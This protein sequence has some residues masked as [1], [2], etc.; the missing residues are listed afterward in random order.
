MKRAF[1][2]S[3][4]TLAVLVATA[5]YAD[6]NR[7]AMVQD[8][9]F[10]AGLIEQDGRKN[11]SAL[12]Q[13]GDTNSASVTQTGSDNIAAR[14]GL[15]A[16]PVERALTQVGDRNDLTVEQTGDGEI[17]FRSF[18]R[19]RT[20]AAAAQNTATVVQGG[21]DDNLVS[22]LRQVN[23]DASGAVNTM[24]VT[25]SGDGNIIGRRPATGTGP[26][27]DQLG[28]GNS[29]TVTQSGKSNGAA[30]RG[31]PRT[32]DFGAF[33]GPFGVEQGTALQD[34]NTNTLVYDAMGNLNLFGTEQVGRMNTATAVVTGNRNENLLLQNGSTNDAI[35]T[36]D[37]NANDVVTL[38]YIGDNTASTIIS[39][40]RN[41]AVT[42]QFSG[43]GSNTSSIVIDGDLAAGDGNDVKILQDG[44]NQS[45]VD[46]FG[47]RSEVYVDQD[48]TNTST[49]GITGATEGNGN[50]VD[51]NQQNA[52]VLPNTSAIAISGD[53]ND[54]V[55]DQ[56]EQNRLTVSVTGAAD[57]G[58][59]DEG[60]GNTLSIFQFGLNVGTLS[61]S[62]DRN[63]VILFQNGDRMTAN[64]VATITISGTSNEGDA[65]SVR[66][67]Q[68]GL[69]G[70]ATVD[71]TGDRNDVTVSHRGGNTASVLIGGANG[72]EGDRN[73]LRVRQSN[74]PSGGLQNIVNASIYGS[75]NNTAV[76]FTGADAIAAAGTEGTGLEPGD[77]F[78]R[79]H[80]NNIELSIGELTF[81]SN[82]NSVAFSQRGYNNTIIGTISGGD[83]NQVAVVQVGNA[84]MT[85]FNQIGSFNVLGVTQ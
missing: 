41:T 67:D 75:E 66:V 59:P 69:D 8:G 17:L 60:N 51:V 35:Q 22:S 2:A 25:Q 72:G 46:I 82:S 71:I 11:T 74:T 68:T 79:G 36:I 65:N 34:G 73:V 81:E 48:G 1:F 85:S 84:N 29:M 14:L 40:S 62:G 44:A 42:D 56:I 58:S 57:A 10:N 19:G 70:I 64:N 63:N 80:G 54:V 50:Y 13:S 24:T 3:A 27:L 18:Q 7:A 83:A 28:S 15:G 20:G 76:S 5:G 16:D 26:S 30:S 32:G 9:S 77:I 31:N 33:V 49:I 38:Q 55:V 61:V 47:D 21:G 4:S 12:R 39:G 53:R 6:E 37:G 78:Q 23:R 52:G 43:G 45:A